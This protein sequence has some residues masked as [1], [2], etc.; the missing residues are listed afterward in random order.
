MCGRF[1]LFSE[2]KIFSKFRVKIRKNYNISP[3]NEV[4][5]INKDLAP[6]KLKWGIKPNWK[7]T[8]IINARNETLMKKK[9]FTNSKKCVFVADGYFEWVREDNQKVA[10]YHYLKNEL[11][12]FAGIYNDSSCCIVTNQSFDYLSKI[13]KRQ[14]F[15]LKES[16]I[17]DWI[18]ENQNRISFNNIVYFHRVSNLVNRIWN[19]NPELINEIK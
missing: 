11:M 19:N 6:M 2:K 7:K 14:P 13:H 18:S 17:K 3:N 5:I 4:L 8:L 15:L 16:Q 10:F 1:S 9:T 12:Y